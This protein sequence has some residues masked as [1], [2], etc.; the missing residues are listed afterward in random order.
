MYSRNIYTDDRWSGLLRL[1]TR[2]R[3]R[4]LPLRDTCFNNPSRCKSQLLTELYRSDEF[5]SIHSWPA[6]VRRL[7]VKQHKNRSERFRLFNFLWSNGMRPG[8]AAYWVMW[9]GGYDAAAIRDMAD[10]VT[11]AYTGGP[12]LERLTRTSNYFLYQPRNMRDIRNR[13]EE[14]YNE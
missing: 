11:D 1:C 12:G 13:W 7:F 4:D 5:T 10:L 6:D 2:R 3:T 14:R 8:S 9:H